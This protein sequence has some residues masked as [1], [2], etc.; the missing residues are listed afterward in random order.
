MAATLQDVAGTLDAFFRAKVP[1]VGAGVAGDV[2]LVFDALGAPF[3]PAEF[4][5]GLAPGQES[6]F[7]SQRAAQIADALPAANLLQAG[8]WLARG[9]SR[10]SRFY[11]ALVEES[12]STA[13]TASARSAFEARKAAARR[14]FDEN[15]LLDVA[16]PG[17]GTVPVGVNDAHYATAMSPSG[18]F[19]PDSGN[20]AHFS[21]A[22]QTGVRP[23]AIKP[24]IPLP[25]FVWQIPPVDPDPRVQEW[26]GKATELAVLPELVKPVQPVDPGLGVD[27]VDFG[28]LESGLVLV[29]A[30]SG[31]RIFDLTR[32]GRVRR[33]GTPR[34]LERNVTTKAQLLF[35]TERSE[36]LA[37]SQPRPVQSEGFS[38]S[39]DYCIVS[40]DRPWWDELF[41]AADGWELPGFS[42]GELASGS[43]A[44]PASLVTLVTN[45]M[46]VIRNLVIK[47]NWQTAE[48]SAVRAASSLGPFCIAGATF[49]EIE[50][51]RPG[52]QAIAWL[53]Q[54]PP[55]LPPDPD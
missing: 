43:A 40:F 54:V 15:R 35:A 48:L 27:P 50:L 26:L 55:V 52:L 2:V 18:W 23:P 46:V 34:F 8:S 1:S 5:Y 45:G 49:N 10:L 51:R 31:R 38:V 3:N 20:W 21:Q 13:T 25:E 24:L 12:R 11:R 19:H 7:A 22:E 53:C 44:T 14:S 36:V 6:V 30:D 4:G 9:S 29:H 41:L 32:G 16:M 28:L 33:T 47:A 42:T 39:F 37:V 17:A